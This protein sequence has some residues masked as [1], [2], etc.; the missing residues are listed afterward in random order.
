[1]FR[2]RVERMPGYVA[3]MHQRLDDR[4]YADTTQTLAANYLPVTNYLV[5]G[6]TA[7]GT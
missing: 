7:A 4:Q 3:D 1:M 6:S 5:T 2:L